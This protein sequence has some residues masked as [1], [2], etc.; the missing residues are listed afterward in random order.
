MIIT[1]LFTAVLLPHA[2]MLNL[3]N[4]GD[5]PPFTMDAKVFLI[6]AI[7]VLFTVAILLLVAALRRHRA[8]VYELEKSLSVL[9]AT[10]DAIVE[11]VLVV[12]CD[13]AVT[14]FNQQFVEMWHIPRKI[15]ETRAS[16]ADRST[17][18]SRGSALRGGFFW[19]AAMLSPCRPRRAE[20]PRDRR[21]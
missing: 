19:G 18:P 2:N 21:G 4:A 12:S 7:V 15:A 11:G 9:N 17:M 3:A 5:A 20:T 16:R 8:D 10:L 13:G 6:F 1:W 14:A